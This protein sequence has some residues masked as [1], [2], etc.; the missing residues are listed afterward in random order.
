M[1]QNIPKRGVPPI[2]IYKEPT[3]GIPTYETNYEDYHTAVKGLQCVGFNA[4]LGEQRISI[5]VCEFVDK[6]TVQWNG[7]RRER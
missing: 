7:R 6:E 4:W 1:Q 3:E 2:A 5:D